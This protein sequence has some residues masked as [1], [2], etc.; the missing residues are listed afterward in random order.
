MVQIN[1]SRKTLHTIRVQ[2]FAVGYAA[3]N[4]YGLLLPTSN[5]RDWILHWRFLARRGTE[6]AERTYH[7]LMN[8]KT[9]MDLTL[10]VA[11][12]LG[13]VQI[14]TPK[15]NSSCLKEARHGKSRDS[16]ESEDCSAWS[17]HGD[18]SGPWNDRE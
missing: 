1:V 2:I 13:L 12:S 10:T 16:L 14:S 15:V 9:H 6:S 4:M 11:E 18:Q 3:V 7:V 8:Y 17:T 5:V